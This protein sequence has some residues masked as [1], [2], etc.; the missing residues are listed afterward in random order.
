MPSS[1]HNKYQLETKLKQ[2]KIS[3]ITKISQQTPIVS[4]IYIYAFNFLDI[5]IVSS[6][7]AVKNSS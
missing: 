4:N 6:D 7:R 1:A 2:G 3:A 5:R